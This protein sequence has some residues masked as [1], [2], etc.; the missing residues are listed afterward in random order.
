MATS[1]QTRLGL[2]KTR[3]C[4]PFMLRRGAYLRVST[5][6]RELGPRPS[7]HS[8][9]KDPNYLELSETNSSLPES[10]NIGS[11][12]NQRT[13]TQPHPHISLPSIL[14]YASPLPLRLTL[15]LTSPP[16]TRLYRA[17]SR[18]SR[19]CAAPSSWSCRCPSCPTGSRSSAAGRR[20]STASCTS[21]TRAR[22]RPSARLSLTLTAA[23]PRRPPTRAAACRA[24]R[25]SRCSSPRLS[26][27]SRTRPFCPRSSACTCTRMRLL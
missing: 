19:T 11:F 14:P 12:M 10:S 22:A 9:K 21:A 23:T 27:S 26:S 3:Q 20:T 5:W 18:R 4:V 7:Q 13:H 2:C 8:A 1:W 15:I 25:A 6:G 17:T 16:S 24:P